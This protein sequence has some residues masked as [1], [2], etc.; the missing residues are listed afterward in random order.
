MRISYRFCAVF[1]FV[2]VLFST[3]ATAATISVSQESAP[4]AGDFASNVLGTIDIF[5]TTGTLSSFYSYSGSQYNGPAALAAD[6]SH[7]F[8]VSASN[9]LGL[10]IVH[11]NAQFNGNGGQAEMQVDL[12]GDTAGYLVHDDPVGG[13]DNYNATGT[14]FQFQNI[15]NDGVTDGVV[16]G[17]L[18]GN[19]S[20]DIQFADLFDADGTA[21]SGLSSWVALS[22]DGL[23]G[24]TELGLVL[25]E[26]R[27]VRLSSVPVPAALWLFG[28]GLLG[29][30]GVARKEYA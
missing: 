12:A 27:R 8:L 13:R 7:V 2:Y 22:S 1:F 20:V 11:D 28:S 4:G 29:L 18:D 3:Y 25:E 19:W 17:T 26:G 16:I 6:Q 9:G 24:Q 10:F 21:F 23:G 5:D 15:W 14:Q 30:I